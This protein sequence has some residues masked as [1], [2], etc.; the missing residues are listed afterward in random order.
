MPALPELQRAFAAGLRGQP[1]DVDAWADGDAISAAA[2][3]R[4]YRNNSRAVF[5]QALEVTYPVLRERVGHDYFRQLAHFYRLACPSDAGDLHEA[6]RRFPG[7]LRSHLDGDPHG[8]LAELAALEWAVAEAGVA[9]DSPVAGASALAGLAPECVAGVR[10]R[11]VPSLRL[12][13]AS[14]PVLTVWRSGQ[15]GADRAA[16]DLGAGAEYVLVH[17]TA[18]TVQLRGLQDT[19]LGFVD[20]IARGATLEAAV[21]ESALPLDRLPLLLHALFAEQAVAEVLLPAVP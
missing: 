10:L 11:F 2:R 21:E 13:S 19:E 15:P 9:A 3:L 6:G 16:V 20:A 4:V 18:D 8:W 14:V 12:V 7:F 5:G 1:H 17:R